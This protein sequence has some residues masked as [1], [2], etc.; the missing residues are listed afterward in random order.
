[1]I[2]ASSHLGRI[3]NLAG[4]ISAGPSHPTHPASL[5]DKSGKAQPSRKSV[6]AV[7]E[8]PVPSSENSDYKEDPMPVLMIAL[9]ALVCFGLIGI[10]LAAAV[11]FE[12]KK[13]ATTNKPV[14]RKAA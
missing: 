2:P 13:S 9:F 3:L 6:T 10:L 1:V 11:V 4:F 7:T 14:H 12:P 8:P 5:R